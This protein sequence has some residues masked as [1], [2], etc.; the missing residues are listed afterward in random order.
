MLS[1]ISCCCKRR[2]ELTCGCKITHA[3][4]DFA[5]NPVLVS[6]GR[7]IAASFNNEKSFQNAL[8]NA[9]EHFINLSSR[10]PEYISLFM[11]DKLRKVRFPSA[12]AYVPCPA[13]HLV[14]LGGSA[15]ASGS[16]CSCMLWHRA[17]MG[18]LCCPGQLMAP[19]SARIR[20]V[21][22][23]KGPGPQCPSSQPVPLLLADTLWS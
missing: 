4:Y 12:R 16:R 8:N 6:C 19:A 22:R 15:Q 13:Y 9:F 1:N 3:I 21:T 5:V 7:L 17:V 20:D 10:A 14:L 2:A 23:L 11:D 18:H